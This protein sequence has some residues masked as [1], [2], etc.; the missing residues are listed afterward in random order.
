MQIQSILWLSLMQNIADSAPISISSDISLEQ[1]EAQSDVSG[2]T[3]DVDRP[4]MIKRLN[5]PSMSVRSAN[6]IIPSG[7]RAVGASRGSVEIFCKRDA[8]ANPRG[9]KPIAKVDIISMECFSL[10]GR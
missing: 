5:H 9:W 10:K 3:A 4:L 7:K 1:R 2:R 6:V 8:E